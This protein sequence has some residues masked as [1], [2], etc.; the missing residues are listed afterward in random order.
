MEP[1]AIIQLVILLIAI[2]GGF[3][4]QEH[5]LTRIE[6][7]IKRCPHV[8]EKEAPFHGSEARH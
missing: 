1:T 6:E 3:V 8:N 4:K 5:R 7:G 2:I